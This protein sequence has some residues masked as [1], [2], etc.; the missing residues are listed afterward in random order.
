MT[1]ATT[2]SYMPELSDA[3]FVAIAVTDLSEDVAYERETGRRCTGMR[4]IPEAA[5]RLALIAQRAV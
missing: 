1:T 3:E 5:L 4:I 2:T